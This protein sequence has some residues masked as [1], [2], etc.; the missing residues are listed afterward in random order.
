MMTKSLT[1]AYFVWKPGDV[2]VHNHGVGLN[3]FLGPGALEV[4]SNP[5]FSPN[6]F[7]SSIV[8]EEALPS[9][10]V[11]PPHRLIGGR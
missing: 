2:A 10:R 4:F 7:S 11:L 8:L 1:T 3:A 9:I 6:V 5:S